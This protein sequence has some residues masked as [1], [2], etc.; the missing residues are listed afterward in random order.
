MRRKLRLPHPHAVTDGKKASLGLMQRFMGVEAQDDPSAFGHE[1]VPLSVSTA[2][3]AVTI[4]FDCNL[5]SGAGVVGEIR[6][7]WVLAAKACAYTGVTQM[8]PE[9]GF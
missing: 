2:I 6:P 5:Q 1:A 9:A 8:Q 4:D 7:N 3:V